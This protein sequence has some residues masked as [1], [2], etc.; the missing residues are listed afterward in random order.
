MTRAAGA[1]SWSRRC[2]TGGAGRASLA[3]PARSCG[4]NCAFT[5]PPRLTRLILALGGLKASGRYPEF[6][7]DRLLD[8]LL[9]RPGV[10]RDDVFLAA[11][12]VEHGIGLLV[13]FAEP[14]FQ[15][16]GG[17]ILAPDQLAA[18]DVAPPLD[19]RSVVDQ[20]VVHPAARAQ[21]PG[22]HPARHLAVGQLEVDHPVEVVALQEELR[23][24]LAAREAVDDEPEVPV[25][26]VEPLFHHVLDEVVADQQPGRHR[27]PDLRAELR[28]V[29]HVPP[30]DVS[31]G[32]VL[33]VE[34]LGEHLR[35]SSL[36]A[37]LHAHD[38]V[39]PHAL[40]FAW[41][42]GRVSKISAASV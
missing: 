34:I 11:E 6:V 5:E 23:L 3:G 37:A 38:H 26:L 8:L 39:F 30:E 7:P 29:L 27:A 28:A 1:W 33:E 31:D 10:D 16:V 20:V 35:V 40:T 21:P 41:N 18:A 25:V 36:A 14:D 12:D 22:E 17:V 15:R 13:V 4:P 42:T 9:V 24:A 2:A 32:D 19:G